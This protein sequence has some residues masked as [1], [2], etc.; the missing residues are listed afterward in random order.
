MPRKAQDV[1]DAELAVLQVLWEKGEGT[2]RDLVEVLYPTG[3]ASDLATVQKLLKRLEKKGCLG[4]NRNVWP[5]IFRPAIQ[6]SELIRRRLETTVDEL[7]E[8]SFSPLLAHL[9]TSRRLSK[10]E[11]EMLRDLLDKLD[12]ES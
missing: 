6:R 11:C 5:H 3:T 8:G 12:A 10:D 4:R 2:V 7:C 9:V 1:T